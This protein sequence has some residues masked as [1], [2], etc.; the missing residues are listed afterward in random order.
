MTDVATQIKELLS[1]LFS[2]QEWQHCFLVDIELKGKRI[3]VFLDSDK[4]IN[5]SICKRVSR[6]LEE[7]LDERE[8]VADD[9]ILEVSSPGLDRP[10]K[11]LRQYKKNIARD[12]DIKLL[13]GNR[14][15]GKLVGAEEE[16]IQVEVPHPDKSKKEKVIKKIGFKEINQTKI[17]ISF[18]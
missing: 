13:S 8:D 17:K 16:F 15:S 14:L 12:V 10:L 1:K 2:E 4:G 18:K 6:W 9:Y 3:N 7:A 5:F 11:L